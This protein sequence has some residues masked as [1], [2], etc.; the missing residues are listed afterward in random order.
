MIFITVGGQLPFERMIR[1]TDDALEQS[2]ATALNIIA[3]TNHDKSYSLKNT[4]VQYDKIPKEKFDIIF[5]QADLIISHAGMGNI[6]SAIKN[7]KKSIF[8]PRKSKLG[9]HR[10]DHQIDTS[11]ALSKK[12]PFLNFAYE[13][14]DFYETFIKIISEPPPD[15]KEEYEIICK[16]KEELNSFINDFVSK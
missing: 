2:K 15:I 1:Y 7:N 6:L 13:Y 12:Y 8:I 11:Q 10:T 5:N 14:N 4:I 16:N 9:E 3:Q